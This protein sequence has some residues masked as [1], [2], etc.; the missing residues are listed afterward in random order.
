MDCTQIPLK[1]LTVDGN[2]GKLSVMALQSML[3]NQGLPTGPIDGRMGRKTA[4]CLQAFLSV[5]GH[6]AGPL[7][8]RLGR[9]SV[10][11]LQQWLRDQGNEPGPIDGLWGAQTTRALQTVLNSRLVN[12]AIVAQKVG[13]STSGTADLEATV[14]AQRDEIA[15]LKTQLGASVANGQ[16]V[17]S[18]V[19][20][21][22]VALVVTN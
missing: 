2:F 16:P 13:S 6:A 18:A 22:D 5:H 17:P 8:G 11:A 15:Q 9:R 14:K 3:K 21:P 4:K 7:D 1:E 20:L 12:G 19:P 10:R